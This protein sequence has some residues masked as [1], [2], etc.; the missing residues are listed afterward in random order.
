MMTK[1]PEKLIRLY[2]VIQM[3]CLSEYQVCGVRI[4][5]GNSVPRQED[6]S[7]GAMF[8]HP[9]EHSLDIPGA[10]ARK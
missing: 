4:H 2:I 5:D 9:G 7:I 8:V 10:G 1:I 6:M 3:L